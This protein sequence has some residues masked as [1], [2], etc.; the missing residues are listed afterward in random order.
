MK[1]VCCCNYG[2]DLRNKVHNSGLL[3]EKLSC[4]DL[5]EWG[6]F[7]HYLI[8]LSS[9]LL[10]NLHENQPFLQTDVDFNFS[11]YLLLRLL[12]LEA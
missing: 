1:N 11:G 2:S 3:M 8:N 7:L 10:G 4:G 12:A 9:L 5:T 6:C